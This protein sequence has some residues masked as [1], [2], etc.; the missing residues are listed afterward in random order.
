MTERVAANAD[1]VGGLQGF[2]GSVQRIR[3]M[4]VDAAQ[5]V[6]RGPGTHSARNSFVIR[7]G[8]ARAR[9]SPLTNAT[10]GDVVHRSRTGRG[11]AAGQRASQRT[12]QDVH[13]PLRSLDVPSGHG[14]GRSSVDDAPFL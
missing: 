7:E 3:H 14:S 2:N 5:S 13:N 10:K 11:Y 8:L 6:N 9:D 4:R 12:E 1:G